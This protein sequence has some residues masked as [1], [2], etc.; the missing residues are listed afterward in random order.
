[1]HPRGRDF[2]IN[3]LAILEHV[4]VH[5][6][7]ARRSHLDLPS[8]LAAEAHPGGARTAQHLYEHEARHSEQEA[9]GGRR[10]RSGQRHLTRPLDR[11]GLGQNRQW[12]DI[13]LGVVRIWK[14]VGL[15][16]SASLASTPPPLDQSARSYT[17]YL[18]TISPPIASIARFIAL[19]VSRIQPISPPWILVTSA[20]SKC[21]A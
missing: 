11:P 6:E 14:G 17:L 19:L 2:G 12:P 21:S 9:A 16:H 5:E 8:P 7:G 13:G 18:F 10:Q 20:M 4:N 3:H 15:G 1:V